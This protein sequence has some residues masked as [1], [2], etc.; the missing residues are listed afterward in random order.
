MLTSP[1]PDISIAIAQDIA[2]EQY[3]IHGDIIPL[4]GERDKNF[5]LSTPNGDA[6]VMKF[7]NS[8]DDALMRDF[9]EKILLHLESTDM[10]LSVPRLIKTRNGENHF[11]SI[12]NHGNTIFGI[13]IT[14]LPGKTQSRGQSDLFYRHLGQK[15][16]ELNI[17]MRDFSH[18]AQHRIILWDLRHAGKLRA[19]TEYLPTGIRHDWIV[20]YLE[21]FEQQVLPATDPLRQQVI[22]NDLSSSNLLIDSHHPDQIAGILDFGDMVHAP[23]INELATAASYHMPPEAKN[24]LLSVAEIVKGYQ[25]RIPLYDDELALLYE[26]I[27]ARLTIRVLITEWRSVLFPENSEYILRHNPGAWALLDHFSAI[28]LKDGRQTLINLCK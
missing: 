6:W 15:I 10:E 7:Y 8:T 27:L 17:A 1:P 9:Q 24:P 26:L 14:F 11:Q 28:A 5:R 18:P 12:D 20:D 3:G 13:L 4:S 22:H 25:R 21:H 19:S 16:A 23:L 2:H